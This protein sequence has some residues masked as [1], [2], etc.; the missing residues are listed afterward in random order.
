MTTLQPLAMLAWPQWLG[1]AAAAVFLSS[2]LCFDLLQRRVPN[3][4]L[5]A[6]A[7]GALVVLACGSAPFGLHWP[8]AL[9]AAV[10]AFAALLAA[11]AAGVMGAGDVKFAAVLGLWVGMP[12]LGPI[13]IGAGLLAGLHALFW[14]GLRIVQPLAMP[15]IPA[16]PSG[17]WAQIPFAG[18]L[19]LA[20]LA[21]IGRGVVPASA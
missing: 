10:M 16:L 5:V 15:Y 20:A 3:R 4:L 6:G 14:F 17:R 9:A 8:S 11:Y 2:V 7:L 12:L 13:A 21:W 18:Y 1:A 19:A